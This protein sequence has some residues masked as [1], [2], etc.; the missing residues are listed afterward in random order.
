MWVG[1]C[2]IL[3]FA[4]APALLF[5][6]AVPVSIYAGLE[7]IA[8]TLVLPATR[9]NVRSFWHVIRDKPA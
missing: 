3:V 1:G 9:S 7:E 6:L 4:G 5:R 8:I 2:V